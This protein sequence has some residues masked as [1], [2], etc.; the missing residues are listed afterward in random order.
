MLQFPDN[1]ATV[2]HVNYVER[3]GLVLKNYKPISQQTVDCPIVDQA[4]T[5][6]SKGVHLEQV[7]AIEKMY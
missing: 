3:P 6:T 4:E 7:A 1:L 2:S 5:Q